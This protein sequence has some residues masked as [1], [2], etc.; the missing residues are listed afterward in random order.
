MLYLFPKKKFVILG[1]WII[2]AVLVY[3]DKV[4]SMISVFYD[5]AFYH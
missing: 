2:F 4:S 5:G 1:G 3:F